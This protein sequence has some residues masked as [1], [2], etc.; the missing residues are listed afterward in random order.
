MD[1][2]NVKRRDNP[3][4]DRYS[5]LKKPAFG[6]PTEKTDFDKTKRKSLEGYQRVIDRNADFEGGNFNH[7][8]DTTW[9]AIT[10]DLISR[11]AKKKPF[12]PM[13][14]KTTIATV[15]AVEE[16]KI[17]R[18]DQF[19]NESEGGYN[20]FAEAEDEASIED[21]AMGMS[22]DMPENDEPEVDEEK[23]EDLMADHGE[24]LE[25]MID[26]IAE[27]M[28]IEKEEVRDLLCAAIKKLTA[29]EESEEPEEGEEGSEEGEEESEEVV[30]NEDEN[31]DDENFA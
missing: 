31:E 6:G 22:D 7:N 27:K 9:K 2:F 13:Y 12:D 28:E 4:M 1:M 10:R 11:T 16:G 3:S 21:D 20:M 29:E 24:S 5:D 14:A 23:L 30:E 15:D 19:V 25:E 17:M 18:F 26:E 8:Y